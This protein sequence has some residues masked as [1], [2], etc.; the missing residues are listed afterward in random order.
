MILI[1]ID[2]SPANAN[3]NIKL[4]AWRL[5]RVNRATNIISGNF[6]IMLTHTLGPSQL[7]VSLAWRHM[8]NANVTPLG[9]HNEVPKFL[10][11]IDEDAMRDREG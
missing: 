11:A 7:I 5:V 6:Q 9:E 10:W 2:I 3:V 1:S 8:A 4:A